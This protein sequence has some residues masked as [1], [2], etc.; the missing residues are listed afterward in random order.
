[1]LYFKD[2]L[3]AR[4]GFS[5]RRKMMSS[6]DAMRMGKGY[7]SPEDTAEE[8]TSRENQRRGLWKEERA[9]KMEVETRRRFNMNKVSERRSCCT[10]VGKR[11][12]EASNIRRSSNFVSSSRCLHMSMSFYLSLSRFKSRAL[13]VS[14]TVF[15][16]LSIFPRLSLCLQAKQVNPR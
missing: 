16:Y 12:R 9:E 4:V 6:V 7:L 13:F 11:R 2:D 10:E 15:L 1:M 3:V 8:K 14:V 5:D